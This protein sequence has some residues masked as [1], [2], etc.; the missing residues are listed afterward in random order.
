MQFFSG[1]HAC[2]VTTRSL[3][4]FPSLL[5]LSFDIDLQETKRNQ[6]SSLHVL[7]TRSRDFEDSKAALHLFHL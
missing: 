5:G 3:G 6:F 1:H 2:S 7:S 4:N